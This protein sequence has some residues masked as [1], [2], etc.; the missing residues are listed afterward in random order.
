MGEKYPKIP[1]FCVHNIR[2]Y[3]D[4]K[5]FSICINNKICTYHHLEIKSDDI[6]F[7]FYSIYF[8][9]AFE[10]E[11]T[12]HIGNNLFYF[13]KVPWSTKLLLYWNILCLNKRNGTLE[14][15]IWG[16]VEGVLEVKELCRKHFVA[17]GPFIYNS[18]KH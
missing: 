14:K 5:T 6:Y 9:G 12:T 8:S 17:Q 1:H 11:N 10:N 13:I 3:T 15:F 16:I 18:S 2:A 7:I 4:K